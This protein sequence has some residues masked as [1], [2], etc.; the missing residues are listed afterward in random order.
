MLKN[1]RSLIIFSFALFISAC[2][3][4]STP[5]LPKNGAAEDAPY[6]V[7]PGDSLQIFVWRQP[8]L[9]TSIQVRPDGRISSPLIEDLKVSG[10]EP[11]EISSLISDILSKFVRD[12]QVVV[13]PSSFTGIP[14]QQVKIFGGA[15]VPVV[16]PFQSGMTLLDLMIAAGGLTEFAD[17]DSA[18]LYRS[19]SGSRKQYTV[20]LDSILQ[21]DLDKDRLVHPGDVLI[22]PESTF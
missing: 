14:D 19:T 17:G 22:I 16:I 13:I 5:L 11:K 15:N 21:G 18:Q 1:T 12:P 20:S 2:A 7:G 9:T 4:V 10:L 6:L 8:D 3:S